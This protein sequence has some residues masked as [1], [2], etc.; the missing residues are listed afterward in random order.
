MPKFLIFLFEINKKIFQ[1]MP[2][3]LIFLFKIKK[4]FFPKNAE[5][6][7]LFI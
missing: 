3:F 2:K 1:K 5:I 6:F 7:N 4:K